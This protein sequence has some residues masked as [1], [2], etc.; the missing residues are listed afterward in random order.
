MTYMFV[1]KCYRHD[2]EGITYTMKIFDDKRKCYK[3]AVYDFFETNDTAR[4]Y[5]HIK[6]DKVVKREIIEYL[7]EN[8]MGLFGWEHHITIK[9]I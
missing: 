4:Y 5:E 9:T 3:Y 7:C 6:N 8:D 1:H 2:E